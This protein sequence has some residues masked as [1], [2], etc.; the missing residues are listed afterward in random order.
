MRRPLIAAAI[1]S[2]VASIAVAETYKLAPVNVIDWKAVYGRIEARD[3]VPARA[4]LGGTLTELHVTEGDSVK[5]GE[6]LAKIV[7]DKLNFQL[8]AIAA[9][10][11]S[12]ESQLANAQS[13]LQ[14]GEELLRQGVSTSQRLDALRTQVDVVT[15]QI[16]ALDAQA[17]VITEQQAEG[18]VLAPV[19]GMVLDVPVSKGAVIMP[20]ETVATMG[21][22]GTFLRLS[23]PERHAN[24]LHQGDP[25]RIEAANGP[26][27][28]K[29]A[30]I[31]PQINNGRVV[32]DVEV[33]GLS[34]RFVDARV[35]VRLPLGHRDALM[36]PTKAIS[37]RDG[38]DMVTM[39]GPDGPV[40][41]V[42][43]PGIVQ[44]IDGQP[45]VEVLSGLESGDSIAAE[46]VTKDAAHE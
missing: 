18:T 30:K 9:Q 17:E 23:I 13:E 32:A 37:T 6:P 16:A 46:A 35:L 4:R 1:L 5:A 36:I 41:R 38:L 28:G 24:S 2:T 40:Q 11:T 26:A 44:E 20:G 21:G 31:Y 10:R 3:L 25:I 34:D 19:D 15:G 29:L 33:E 12:A 27:E 42:I 43:V 8:S 22:G 7:D 45:M 39:E 14:R